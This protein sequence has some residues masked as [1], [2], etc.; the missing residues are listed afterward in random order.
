VDWVNS[1]VALEAGSGG[2]SSGGSSAGGASGGG[3]GGGGVG[4]MLG[5]IQQ[6]EGGGAGG[7]WARQATVDETGFPYLGNANS[8]TTDSGS[9][10]FT[11][12]VCAVYPAE[13]GCE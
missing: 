3:F 10:V 13:F 12:A 11:F 5:D 4:L 2:N 1:R 9:V 7:S 8:P 6:A